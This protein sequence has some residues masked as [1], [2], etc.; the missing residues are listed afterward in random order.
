MPTFLATN[1]LGTRV[2][3]VLDAP[4]SP[5]LVSIGEEAIDEILLWHDRL[6]LFQPHSLVSFINREAW[7]RAVALDD[8]VFG[9]LALCERVHVLSGG[10]FDPTVGRGVD[11]GG[12]RPGGWG[13]LVAL[14][15]DRRTVR[16]ARDGVLL[17]LG[18]IAKGFAL[19]MAA[20]LLRSH[21]G[22]PALLHAGT[23]GVVV[24]GDVPRKIGVRSGSGAVSIV[25]ISDASMCVSAPRGGVRGMDVVVGDGERAASHIVRP[26]GAGDVGSTGDAGDGRGLADTSLVIGGS[27]AEA[28]GWAT[29]LVVLGRRPGGMPGGL[30]SAVHDGRGWRSDGV[31]FVSSDGTEKVC[32]HRTDESF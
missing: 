3:L 9:L 4:G 27:C 17:D 28:D 18:G 24:I 13:S 14:D 32:L 15:H 21:L 31:V 6:S 29:A 1:A 5:G 10:A 2:E 25:S 16:F 12:M 26:V 22:C 23:S 8:D 30:R 7:R 11:E 20:E 19:D